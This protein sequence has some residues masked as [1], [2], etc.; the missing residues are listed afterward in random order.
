MKEGRPEREQSNEIR[1]V[2]RR[3]FCIRCVV[4]IND[5]APPRRATPIVCSKRETLGR[6]NADQRSDSS[7]STTRLSSRV[8]KLR[9]SLLVLVYPATVVIAPHPILS[10]PSFPPFCCLLHHASYDM[11]SR[12]QRQ[13]NEAQPH[14]PALVRMSS[15][16][17][18]RRYMGERRTGRKN[19]NLSVKRHHITRPC[20]ATAEIRTPQLIR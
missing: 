5:T 15:D 7:S 13:H 8:D 14:P 11:P 9:D 3:L 12:Q 1:S 10:Y 4:P 17:R 19:E 20:S 16:P 18:S 2:R 6:R